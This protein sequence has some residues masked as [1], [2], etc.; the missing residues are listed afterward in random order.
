MMK[1]EDIATRLRQLAAFAL[2]FCRRLPTEP[3]A[4]HLGRQLVRAATGGGA[5]YEEARGAESRAD[6]IHKVAIANKEVRETLYW[7]RLAQDVALIADEQELGV[8]IR[9]AEELCAI[10]RASINT[11]RSREASGAREP[12]N[13]EY[14]TG[15]RQQRM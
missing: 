3:G 13:T 14:G 12:A 4:T 11:A 7:L 10:L 2:R 15:N 6:F 8:Y 5:N 9:E 1:G